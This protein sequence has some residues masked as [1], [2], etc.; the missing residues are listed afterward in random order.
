MVPKLVG[1]TAE[2]NHSSHLYSGRPRLFKGN[3]AYD[4][5]YNETKD[6]DRPQFASPAEPNVF[7]SGSI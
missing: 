5:N 7:H 2:A 1:I 6:E 4:Q 3:Y